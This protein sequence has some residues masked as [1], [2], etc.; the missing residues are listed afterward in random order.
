MIAWAASRSRLTT[1]GQ[2]ELRHCARERPGDGVATRSTKS[3]TA[4]G[5]ARPC[6][7]TSGRTVTSGCACAKA[8]EASPVN[9]SAAQRAPIRKLLTSQT[10]CRHEHR[11][12]SRHHAVRLAEEAAPALAPRPPGHRRGG[13]QLQAARFQPGRPAGRGL[14]GDG[15]GEAGSQRSAIGLGRHLQGVELAQDG[16]GGLFLVDD[17]VGAGA[18]EGAG[19]AAHGAVVEEGQTALAQMGHQRAHALIRGREPVAQIVGHAEIAR[20]ARQ[21]PVQLD[22]HVVG[23][24]GRQ[25]GVGAGVVVGIAGRLH[26]QFDHHLM[27]VGASHVDPGLKTFGVGHEGERHLG[28]QTFDR[29]AGGGGVEAEAADDEGHHRLAVRAERPGVG[30][31]RDAAVG[32]DARQGAV[33]AGLEQAGDWRLGQGVGRSAHRRAEALPRGHAGAVRQG[34]EG[35]AHHPRALFAHQGRVDGTKVLIDVQTAEAEGLGAVLLRLVR[36]DRDGRRF[37]RVGLGL[38]R[39]DLVLA[40]LGDDD[41]LRRGGQFGQVAAGAQHV[42]RPLQLIVLVLGVVGAR[43]FTRSVRPLALGPDGGVQR[44]RIGRLGIDEAGARNDARLRLGAGD[45]QIRLDADLLDRPTRRRVVARRGDRQGAVAAAAQ[46]D[47]RLHRSLAEAGQADH[48]R[49]LLIL[50][51]AGDDLG[52]RGRAVV[53]QHHHRQT[54]GQVA[55]LGGV[56]FDVLGLAAALADDLAAL[57]EGVRHVD[58]RRQQAAAVVAQVQH[59]TLQARLLAL[60]PLD[61]LGQLP[62]GVLVEGRDAQVAEVAFQTAGDGFDLDDFARQHDLARLF[63]IAQEGDGDAGPCGAAQL[64]RD[65]GDAETSRVLAIDGADDVARLDPGATGRAVV[66]RRDDLHQSAFGGDRQADAGILARCALAQIAERLGG[67]VVGVRVERRHHPLQGGFDQLLVVDRDD[68]GLLDD[69]QDVAEQL[70]HPEGLVARSL[71]GDSRRRSAQRQGGGAHEKQ[72]THSVSFHRIRFRLRSSRAA[73]APQR[74]ARQLRRYNQRP[75]RFERNFA[76]LILLQPRRRIDGPF[77]A[78]QFEIG[79]PVLAGAAQGLAVCHALTGLD[80]Q[81]VKPRDH[82]APTGAQVQDHHLAPLLEWPGIG[83]TAR[84]RGADRFMA[85]APAP[86]GRAA[87]EALRGRPR[88]RGRQA[89]TACRQA[90]GGRLFGRLRH[91]R[92]LPAQFADTGFQRLGRALGPRGLGPQHRAQGRLARRQPLDFGAPVVLGALDG[93]QA[94]AGQGGE[95]T[96]AADL[97]LTLH[98][99]WRRAPYPRPDRPGSAEAAAACGSSSAGRTAADPEPRVHATGRRPERPRARPVPSAGRAGPPTAR[100]P[101]PRPDAV[102]AA[103]GPGRRSPRRRRPPRRADGGRGPS[104]RGT[105]PE[106]GSVRGWSG[107]RAGWPQARPGPAAGWK[108]SEEER[109]RVASVAMIG[110]TGHGQ[111]G[112][113]PIQLFGQHGAGQGVGPGAEGDRRWRRRDDANGPTRRSWRRSWGSCRAGRS[114]RCPE[115]C[116]RRV[117]REWPVPARSRR[118]AGAGAHR[119]TRRYWG[120]PR[121]DRL[122]NGRNPS[123]P[124]RAPRSKRLA[125]CA[126][127]GVSGGLQGDLLKAQSSTPGAKGHPAGGDSSPRA[128]RAARIAVEER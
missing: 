104:R 54:A 73:R 19:A 30:L 128:V 29:R 7:A 61:R 126:V 45:L 36:L 94:L 24:A 88:D 78:A 74:R 67:H 118:P 50:Q 25:Q 51:G 93:E 11:Y 2:I 55:R 65:L 97:G 105:R 44:R 86:T 92:R 81:T 115:P 57:Q 68:I 22:R 52:R 64:V 32:G 37:G 113:G 60:Q 79:F 102:R 69:A 96:D 87:A 28:R 108:R 77:L 14:D 122:R 89:A 58:G 75:R 125:S 120:R 48:R 39:L 123:G 106:A 31:G 38:G 124:F 59:I 42:Q 46:R 6:T 90:G 85:G 18:G 16:G 72:F 107:P 114:G 56:T 8:V 17:A 103:G 47:H 76:R 117:W 98:Q 101:R 91:L 13:R 26:R 35:L 1:P 10:S 66:H 9:A 21:Q 80:F 49:P 34:D 70:Q 83:D 110:R 33:G 127:E 27:A 41:P 100:R 53:D 43:R 63:A 95:T 111:D 112:H 5:V 84:R 40:R 116:R 62:A 3:R 15:V 99:G 20:G 109:P 71:A 4:S 121:P 82:G 119:R 23:A 12:P